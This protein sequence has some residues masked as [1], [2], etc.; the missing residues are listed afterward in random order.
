MRGA[1]REYLFA[2]QLQELRRRMIPYAEA[3]G[4]FTDEEVFREIS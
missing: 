1:L 2:H 3:Q 4:V